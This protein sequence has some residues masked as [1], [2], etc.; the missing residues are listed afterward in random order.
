MYQQGERVTVRGVL[1]HLDISH[2]EGRQNN[3]RLRI[4]YPSW[5]SWSST[6]DTCKTNYTS[7]SEDCKVGS[8]EDQRERERELHKYFS[9]SD[10]YKL[11]GYSRHCL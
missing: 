1:Q 7:G 3:T 4:I 5:L 11:P 10:C 6:S 9:L 8:L 2:G